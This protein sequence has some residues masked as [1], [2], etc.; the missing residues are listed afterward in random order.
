MPPDHA[1]EAFTEGPEPTLE[2]LLPLEIGIRQLASFFGKTTEDMDIRE[3]IEKLRL[4]GTPGHTEDATQ[5]TL[6][7]PER[8]RDLI[9]LRVEVLDSAGL[10]LGDYW[11]SMP[12]TRADQ[13][14]PA[15]LQM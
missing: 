3:M 6:S 1:P 13:V 4:Q 2:A 11:V 10:T 9:G 7:A 14:A 5:L 8:Y 15:S 12:R